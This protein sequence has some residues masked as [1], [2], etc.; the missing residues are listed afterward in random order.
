MPEWTTVLISFP[1]DSRMIGGMATM[2]VCSWDTRKLFVDFW[3]QMC[4]HMQ[5]DPQ[6][7]IIGY[8]I[9]SD[10]VR[11]A[12]QE[13]STEE[14]YTFAM[15]S[16]SKKTQNA[17]SKTHMLILQNLVGFLISSPTI[18]FHVKNHNFLHSVQPDTPLPPSRSRVTMS[19]SVWFSR[20]LLL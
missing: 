9:S 3:L 2:R 7:I 14:D 16:I 5:L 6:T 18:K 1:V 17:R 8:K 20:D 13:I 10:W 15:E 12:A 19:S 4:E 11:D